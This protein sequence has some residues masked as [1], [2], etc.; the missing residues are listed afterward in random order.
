MIHAK[1]NDAVVNNHEAHITPNGPANEQSDNEQSDAKSNYA[2]AHDRE[3][4]IAPN[5]P[6]E[7]WRLQ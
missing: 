2:I 7:R 6:A 5:G 4:H 1:S 3:A